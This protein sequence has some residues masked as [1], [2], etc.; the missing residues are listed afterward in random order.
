[1]SYENLLPEQIDQKALKQKAAQRELL[2][3]IE[4]K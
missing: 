3:Q 2:L 4:E 1:L